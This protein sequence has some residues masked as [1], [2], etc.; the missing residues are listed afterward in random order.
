M[1][2]KNTILLIDD[3]CESLLPQLLASVQNDKYLFI[4]AETPSKAKDLLESYSNVIDIVLL[5]L[6]FNKGNIQGIDF[7]KILKTEFPNLPVIILTGSDSAKNI[8]TAV[9]CIKLGANDYFGKSKLEPHQLFNR[10]DEILESENNKIIHS[11]LLKNINNT[12]N[13]NIVITKFANGSEENYFGNF[14]Y[15]IQDIAV[16]IN[17]KHQE[18]IF[19]SLYIWQKDLLSLLSLLKHDVSCKLRFQL[20][21]EE[22]K[23]IKIYFVFNVKGGSE[24]EARINAVE[25]F[26]EIKI[27]FSARYL[28][29]TENYKVNHLKDKDPSLDNETFTDY[30]LSYL[31]HNIC[32]CDSINEKRI[33]RVQQVLSFENYIEKSLN[34]L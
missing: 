28:S 14:V 18:C 27:L 5:D 26:N 4:D 8:K 1:N 32:C 9:D 6:K 17:D 3:D 13:T 24:D 21:A 33:N 30:Y 22:N 2:N 23:K 15:S 31:F 20:I 10:I 34:S 19:N 25:V 7:L 16:A 29:E 11:R 12:E